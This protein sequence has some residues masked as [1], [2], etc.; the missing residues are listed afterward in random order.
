MSV[1]VKIEISWKEYSFI[2]T[3]DR[4]VPRWQVSFCDPTWF[5]PSAMLRPW[6][7]GSTASLCR[8]QPSAKEHTAWLKGKT[9]GVLAFYTSDNKLKP[10]SCK[11]DITL[12]GFPWQ[13]TERPILKRGRA[14]ELG[15]KPSCQS[16]LP[17][18][19]VKAFVS[20]LES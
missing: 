8:R 5:S 10:F 19:L 2:R 16:S 9:V 18:G 15:S 11:C 13:S 17:K 3:E 4:P 20:R 7:L 6:Y 1:L 12:D 14:M